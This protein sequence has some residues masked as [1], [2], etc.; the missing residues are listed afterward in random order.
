[1]SVTITLDLHP[2]LHL[3]AR[4]SSPLRGLSLHAELPLR[5]LSLRLRW[6][7]VVAEP[8]QREELVL[9]PGIPLLIEPEISLAE[10]LLRRPG[11][12]S[13]HAELWQGEALLARASAAFR[14]LP[15]DLWPGDAL[16][17]SLLAAFVRP[18]EAA[19]LGVI[20]PKDLDAAQCAEYLFSAIKLAHQAP[21]PGWS[22]LGQPLGGPLRISGPATP[23]EHAVLL[24]AL[25]EGRGFAPL[26]LVTRERPLVGVWLE[27]FVCPEPTLD[28]PLLLLTRLE[29]GELLV[30]DPTSDDF[31]A[32]RAAALPALQDT[33]NFRFAV[34]ILAARAAEIWPPDEAPTAPPSAPSGGRLERYKRELLDLSLRNRLL[35]F[36]EGRQ[37]V[38]L[39]ADDTDELVQSL[40][41]GRAFGLATLPP[42][43]AANR[44]GEPQRVYLADAQHRG[45]L[46]AQLPAPELDRRLLELHRRARASVQD[47][48]VVTLYLAVGML[49]WLDAKE[50]AHLAPLLLVPVTLERSRTGFKLRREGDDPR[51]NVTL[52]ARCDL[53]TA[54]LR[55]DEASPSA[56][57]AAW[58]AVAPPGWELLD[59]L[60]LGRFAFTKAEMW[61]DLESRTDDILRNP[62]VR[63]LFEGAGQI[64][65]FAAPP[66][67]P[68]AVDAARRPAE[69]LT[70]MDADPTQLAAIFA[71]EDGSSFVLQGP[72]GTG[73]SQTITNLIAGLLARDRTVLF[74]SEKRAALEVVERR[75]K[76]V[77]L[78][79][80]VLE[81]HAPDT[82]RKQILRQLAE[83]VRAA[84]SPPRGD[85]EGHANKLGL[86][87]DELNSFAAL[88][89]T[90]GPY[91]VTVQGACAALA[92]LR[93]APELR[94]DWGDGPT[95]EQFEAIF[96]AMATV[97]HRRG[98][99]EPIGS[100][101]LQGVGLTQWTPLTE[102]PL[103][104]ALEALAEAARQLHA[105]SGRL[106]TALNLSRGPEND[107]EN[108]HVE[109]LFRL[110]EQANEVPAASLR[111]DAEALRARARPWLALAEQHR[112]ARD[113]LAPRWQP[114]LRRLDL[115]RLTQRFQRHIGSFFSFLLLFFNRWTLRG[116]AT[117][118]LP[119]NATILGDLAT[120]TVAR[121]SEASLSRLEPEATARFGALW[122]GADTDA[123][124]IELRVAWIG[125]VRL[126]AREAAAWAGPEDPL[127]GLC[128][129]SKSLLGGPE[130]LAWTAAL[131]QYRQRREA[132][133]RLLQLDVAVWG[134]PAPVVGVSAWSDRARLALPKLRDWAAYRAA[135]DAA[136]ALGLTPF[137]RAIHDG[138][139][140]PEQVN[141]A[142][143]RSIHQHFW[144]RS[145]EADLRLASGKEHEE[146]IAAWSRLDLRAQELAREEVR[147]RIA[148]RIPPLHSPGPEHQLLRH[149]LSLQQNHRPIRRLF[150]EMPSLLRR[151]K[152]CALM[153]PL[154]V[155]RA[156]DPALPGYDVV[157]FD[158]AS[159]IP[160]WEAVGAIARCRQ[161]IVVGDS[162]QLPPTSFF[163]HA[164]DEE[165]LADELDLIEME[166]ILE[167]A[168]VAGLPQ[169]DLRWHYRSQHESLIAFSN[170]QYY[171]DRLYTFPSAAEESPALGVQWV[172]VPDGVYERGGSRT[173]PAEAMAL[174]AELERV[175]DD[176]TRPSVGVVTFSM[177]QQRL[178]EDLVD[179]LT[180][181]RPDLEERFTA[182]AA[183][184]VFVKNLENVQGDERD[185]MLF[186]VCYAADSRGVVT[187]NFGPLNRRG[188]ERR[189]NVAVTRARRR[190][191]VFS[192]LRPEQID[193]GRT[194][195][196]GAKQ[197]R[198]FLEY[199]ARGSAS[200]AGGPADANTPLEREIARALRAEG[201]TVHERVGR[202]GYRVELAVVDPNDPSHYLL[203]IET[204][205]P[206]YSGSACARERDRLRGEVLRSLG[207]R[208]LRVWS[209]DW[210]LDREQT[211]GRIHR[212]LRAAAQEPKPAPP[213]PPEP[214]PD[215]D[216]LQALRE[217]LTAPL[218]SLRPPF[219][220]V[221]TAL[222]YE[223]IEADV[224]AVAQRPEL[225]RRLCHLVSAQSPVHLEA[226]S[227]TLMAAWGRVQLTASV[228]QAIGEALASL[229]K[230][231]RPQ[232]IDGFLWQPGVDPAS[233]PGLRLHEEERREPQHIAPQEVANAAAWVTGVALSIE[234]EALAREL[235][236]LFGFGV[237]PRVREAMDAGVALLLAQGRARD[238][239]GFIRPR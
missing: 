72:P 69:Q 26:L 37:S 14:V 144:E 104:A 196:L 18:R 51:V 9:E 178:I 126:A 182:S 77:G 213:P 73:K 116:V 98:A 214:R 168:V 34:D 186:S 54:G 118:K 191:A 200:S 29:L 46:S 64:L 43:H 33:P 132:V 170:H 152:P 175:L 166:S 162:K 106:G 91:G 146:R 63:H 190:L 210:W 84:E 20:P 192:T 58:R 12:G 79:P 15:P 11:E 53:D 195:A 189:L 95:S 149:Q 2:N 22:T 88:L 85:W 150:R 48:G 39:L 199:A 31:A 102:R 128:A 70:V 40:L 129:E 161:V 115:E 109:R 131:A 179:A 62:I 211:L 239:G 176:P 59:E 60:W 230:A 75:L 188:G 120:A 208:L 238:D 25:L 155:A 207:W 114:A 156:L 57:L 217:R 140:A 17:P 21:P 3:A 235:A 147:A 36:R 212:A 219:A 94:V 49:R 216:A 204:D 117:A 229:P 28:D 236:R 78:G 127:L 7:P 35:N 224:T 8:W 89:R 107:A 92:G 111:E 90:P 103:G 135:T 232:L 165:A 136:T 142:I 50:E 101:P 108:R 227:R 143:L 181:R 187:M 123:R 125:A 27:S 5:G 82:S 198:L 42:K 47:S 157:I 124:A 234:R 228:N 68:D 24:A 97:L 172:P 209:A 231:E 112:Q 169:L 1:M 218:D 99:V 163:A 201:Y 215:P 67:P 183:E 226:A 220:T 41:S 138:S 171:E 13:L 93:Q 61:E 221:W 86:L 113:A 167:E 185:V 233:W 65:P 38:R 6:E 4:S 74:V 134:D 76:S 110:G 164:E 130:A 32:A 44:P 133:V 145:V 96:P 160:P 158:E 19:L 193:L 23:L 100:H 66:V 153:S 154:S 194:S 137:L 56:R 223:E 177:P 184:P 30:F 139:L 71:A 148:A 203:G 87:R 83:A 105:A 173:N 55:D 174:V 206:L 121:D 45:L 225:A 141:D 81:L 202:S 80:F 197:L 151:L 16:P 122:R 159:Q 180:Q 10:A 119:D 52:L 222:S 205:G 237:G